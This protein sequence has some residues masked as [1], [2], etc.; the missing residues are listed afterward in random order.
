MRAL[1]IDGG[2]SSRSLF[3]LNQVSN[4]CEGHHL[5]CI[6]GPLRVES[7]HL[8]EKKEKKISDKAQRA[9][10]ENPSL[11]GT[12]DWGIDET[13]I[14]AALTSRLQL[15]ANSF[16]DS[17]LK[18][19]RVHLKM[20]LWNFFLESKN[21]KTLINLVDVSALRGK[22]YL[23]GPAEKWRTANMLFQ[24]KFL[25]KS[26][27]APSVINTG[28]LTPQLCLR[29]TKKR[30]HTFS[31]VRRQTGGTCRWAEEQPSLPSS[32]GTQSR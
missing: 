32:C 9:G 12:G 1:Y 2:S 25:Q 28:N 29:K 21:K 14:T 11:W 22:Y 16:T 30:S 20:N 18:H 3:L 13:S 4:W 23:S 10:R 6:T 7:H 17:A 15:P 24:G 27:A 5:M 8:V 19:M 31:L 26:V